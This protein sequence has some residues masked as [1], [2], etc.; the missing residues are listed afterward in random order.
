MEPR[1]SSLSQAAALIT[2]GGVVAIPTDT[3]YGLACHP[4][5]AAAAAHGAKLIA[6]KT[7]K[8]YRETR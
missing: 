8:G 4:D 1:E 2:G 6:E 3:V 7:A 5:E